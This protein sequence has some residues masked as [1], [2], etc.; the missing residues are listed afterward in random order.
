MPAGGEMGE[1]PRCSPSAHSP[2]TW[3]PDVWSLERR[4]IYG[5]GSGGLTTTATGG[6]AYGGSSGRERSLVDGTLHG[7]ALHPADFNAIS[8]SSSRPDPATTFPLRAALITTSCYSQ[9]VSDLRPF[10]LHPTAAG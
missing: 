7:M 10:P 9:V 3:L 4:R 2:G 8:V 5:S 6:T 1:T